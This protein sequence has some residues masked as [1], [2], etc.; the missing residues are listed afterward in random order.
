MAWFID[1][2]PA[3]TWGGESINGLHG[4]D[5]QVT[6]GRQR[7]LGVFGGLDVVEVHH[8]HVVR[9]RPAPAP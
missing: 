4:S 8:R 7:R 1:G 6:G 9:H 5:H 3:S 2:G